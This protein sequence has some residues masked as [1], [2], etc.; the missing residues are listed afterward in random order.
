MTLTIGIDV[1]GTKVAGGVVDETGKVLVH[2][3]RDTPAEDVAKTRDVI[4]DLVS[5]LASGRSIEAVGVGAA[6][7]IDASRSTVL[8]APNL[9]WRDEP[10][11]DY[12]SKKSGL[13]VV[14]ENDGNVAAWAEFRHGAARHADDSMVMFTIGTGVGGGIVLGGELV[15]GAHGIAAELGHMLTVPDGH[16]CGCGRLGCIEQYASGSALVRFA[17]AAAREEPQRATALLELAGGAAEAITGPMVTAAAKGGDPVSTEAFAQVGR[18]LGTSL[19]DMA[20]I[21]D[22]QV[23][24]VGGGVIDAGDL[25]MGPTRRSYIDSLAQRSRLPVAEIRPAELGNRAGVIGAADLARRM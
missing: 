3:R 15:R 17:R 2:A 5:E 13:P 25:L 24:V 10:L 1:G 16:Q 12:V 9:A 4:T 19:A 8:F 6:G 11:R 22:P 23:L 20:Q 14:V 18:W 21:L 7:W